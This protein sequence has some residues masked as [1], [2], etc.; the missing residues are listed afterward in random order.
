MLLIISSIIVLFLSSAEQQGVDRAVMTALSAAVFDSECTKEFQEIASKNN[1]KMQRKAY[2]GVY[3]NNLKVDPYLYEVNV[4]NMPQEKWLSGSLTCKKRVHR[5]QNDNSYQLET[6]VITRAD[7]FGQRTDISRS[8]NS[9]VTRWFKNGC[10]IYQKVS[11]NDGKFI[12]GG[13]SCR[14]QNIIASLN[15]VSEKDLENLYKGNIDYF[16]NPSSDTTKS[17]N[18]AP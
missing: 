8:D 12:S 5:K 6:E 17:T 3:I 1:T 14:D 4:E 10:D 18:V 15:S 13:F 2:Q 11:L 16:T 7:G 9:K